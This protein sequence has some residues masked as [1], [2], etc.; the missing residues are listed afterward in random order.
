M[1]GKNIKEKRK[2]ILRKGEIIGWIICTVCQQINPM[3]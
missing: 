3:S 1:K 2:I